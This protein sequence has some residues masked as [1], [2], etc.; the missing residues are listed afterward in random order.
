MVHLIEDASEVII[1]VTCTSVILF[2]GGLAALVLSPVLLGL[3]VI[4]LIKEILK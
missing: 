1:E 3:L 4:W 2:L